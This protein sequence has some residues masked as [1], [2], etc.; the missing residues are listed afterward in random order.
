[1]G[2]VSVPVDDA[3]AAEVV[4]RRLCARTGP[5]VRPSP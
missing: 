3:G 4:G 2:E 1:M 5:R